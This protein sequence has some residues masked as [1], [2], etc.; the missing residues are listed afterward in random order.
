MKYIAKMMLALLASVTLVIPAYA[1]DFSASGTMETTFNS[2]STKADSG[3]NA[4]SAGSGVSST[5][6][7]L[8][9]KSSNT[10][11]DHS[12]SFSYVADWD[13]NLD[14]TITVSGSK[15]VGKWTGSADVSYNLSEVGCSNASYAYGTAGD[16]GDNLTKG[17]NVTLSSGTAAACAASQTGEDRG[18]VTLTDGTMT[19]KLGDSGHLSNQ[20][21]SAS[22]T[23]GG[24]KSMDGAD[25]DLG[26]GAMV[27]SFHGVSIGYKVSD[28]ISATVALQSTGDQNDMLGAMDFVDGETAVY[29]TTGTGVSVSMAAGPAT[30]GVTVANASTADLS[31]AS[32]TLKSTASAMGLGVKIDLGDIDP[33]FSYGDNSVKAG[34][35]ANE[36]NN[37]TY[38]GMDLGLTYA[39][40]SD[41]VV[42]QFGNLEEGVGKDDKPDK[43]SWMEVGYNT[44]LGPAALSLGYGSRSQTDA[45]KT[46]AVL[47]GDGGT[48]S[49]IEVKLSL[50][51]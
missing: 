34:T 18:A 51:F 26:I 50:S 42:V 1:W 2:T 31:G 28:T 24:S 41:T 10:N 19:I 35:A 30:I 15:K 5:G 40:G 20:N 22:S 17:D 46:T 6:K 48:Y 38:K 16:A 37:L 14:Q 4:S 29:G 32:G 36:G 25:A 45:D 47:S 3:A 27:G 8:T 9:L 7:S 44:T 21:V 12:S 43:Y 39:L 33:F 23:A 11:G 49:D 13:G